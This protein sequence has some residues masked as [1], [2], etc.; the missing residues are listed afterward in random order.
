MTGDTFGVNPHFPDAPRR[1]RIQSQTPARDPSS[2]EAASMS[3]DGKVGRLFGLGLKIAFLSLITLGFYRFWG[4]TEVRRYLASRISIMGD[5]FEYTGTGKE[6]FLGFLIAL[7]VLIPLGA[8]SYGIEL[9]LVGKPAFTQVFVTTIQYSLVLFLIGYATFR[10]R[11]YRLSRTVLRSIRFWQTGSSVGYALRM[12][13]F[14]ALTIVT[15]GIARPVGDI[16]LYRYLMQHTWFGSQK[17]EFEGRAGPMMEKWIL[18]LLLVPF[19]LGLSLIWYAAFRMRYLQ[20]QTQYQGIR[21]SLPITFGN[22]VRIYSPYILVVTV[23]FPIIF[24]AIFVTVMP[25]VLPDQTVN[26]QSWI[27]Q[28]ATLLYGVSIAAAFVV[29]GLIAPVLQLVMLTH[30]FVRLVTER[31]EFIGDVDLDAILQSADER[32]NSGEGLADA[33]DIGG[34]LEVGI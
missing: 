9:S 7:A 6:L 15:L 20:S 25:A 26:V 5:R 31:L 11:R 29:F 18:S 8:A 14:L 17:F 33:L 21:F 3:Y 4:K 24:G 19:T 22:L 13:G 34:G 30:R 23:L 1:P 32:P 16:A 27:Q 12:L 10:A 28:N 2:Y